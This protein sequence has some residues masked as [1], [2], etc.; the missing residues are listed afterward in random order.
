MSMASTTPQA[1]PER[2]TD[3]SGAIPVPAKPN[4]SRPY[5][6][7]GALVAVGLTAYGTMA[8]V[9]RG[10]ES[11]DD[12]QIEADVVVVSARVGGTVSKVRV[13]DNQIVKRG[14]VLAEIDSADLSARA[15][16]SAAQ[17][18][19]ARAQAEAS[20]AQVGIV[21]ASSTG[22]LSAAQAQLSGTA[23]AVASADAQIQAAQAS[24]ARAEADAN[25]TDSDL[26]RA[27]SLHKQGAIPQAQF[28]S[29]RSIAQSAR[30]AV[31]LARAQLVA[32]EDGKRTAQTHVAEA[33]G[34]VVQ[35][36]PVDAQ[37]AVA[38]ANADLA[39]ANV[40]AA[41]AALVL[42]NLQLSYA[43]IVSPTDGRLSKLPVREGQQLQIGQQVVTVVP[44]ASYVVANF[45]E[46]Q[47]GAMRPGQRAEITVDAFPGRTF[48]GRLES[49]S[50]GTGSRFSLLPADNAS[51][52]FVKV[53]QR[54]PVKVSWV[55]PPSD[56]PLA[57]GLSADVTVITR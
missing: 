22:G 27:D 8:W 10:R 15:K 16:Q 21:A 52:N 13:I 5:V 42:A 48:E 54:M 32:A 11:T 7:V 33:R 53:V 9:S 31:A 28:D 34:R 38:R 36:T 2:S 37:L 3:G 43:T 40:V 45:K 56:I 4:R 29:A 47:V 39:H 12:A 41:E 23:T 6:I 19:A 50:P 46:T 35:S 55:D 14:D 1:V 44:S 51:G 30:A 25:Q 24:L 26:A 57:A 17:L 18:A 20:D 49:T